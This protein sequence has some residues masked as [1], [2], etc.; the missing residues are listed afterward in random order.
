MLKSVL[1]QLLKQQPAFKMLTEDVFKVVS[2]WYYF[3]IVELTSVVDFRNDPNWIANRLGLP[4]G[5]VKIAVERLKKV[6]LLVDDGGSLKKVSRDYLF[7]NLPSQ[8]IRNHHH[9]TLEL[10]HRALEEQEMPNREFFTICFPMDPKLLP[11]VKT[12]IRE[13]SE[14]LMADFQQSSPKA[15]YKIAVQFFRLD[16]GKT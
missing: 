13:F 14:N 8:A 2:A 12:R 10:A 11:E 6:G 7:E 3:A 1:D 9:Q 15:I 5:E 16:K 4:V